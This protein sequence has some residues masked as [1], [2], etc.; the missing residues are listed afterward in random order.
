MCAEDPA[1]AYF[2]VLRLLGAVNEQNTGLELSRATG[3]ELV[4]MRDEVV[5]HQADQ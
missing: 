5:E 3:L 2:Q 1:H 4:R